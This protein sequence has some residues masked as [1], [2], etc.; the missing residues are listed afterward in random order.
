MIPRNISNVIA[1]GPMLV[2]ALNLI[3]DR[4][5]EFSNLS[6]FKEIFQADYIESYRN[7]MVRFVRANYSLFL[8]HFRYVTLQQEILGK[9]L[10]KTCSIVSEDH[11]TGVQTLNE[12]VFEVIRA[13]TQVLHLFINSIPVGLN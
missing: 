6:I 2:H 4:Y 10:G 13:F 3:R 8:D 7:E 11:K 5:K 12:G 1:L 9:Y